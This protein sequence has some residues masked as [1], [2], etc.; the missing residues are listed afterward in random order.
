[1][2]VYY[3]IA[4]TAIKS[5]QTLLLLH[6][7][8]LL[9]ITALTSSH[10]LLLLPHIHCSY[11]TTFTTTLSSQAMLTLHH[12]HCYFT[13]FNAITFAC[14]VQPAGIELTITD[15]G[16][17]S[18]RKE[19]EKRRTTPRPTPP[20]SGTTYKHHHCC[21]GSGRHGSPNPTTRP[22]A[23]GDNTVP[24]RTS[25]EGRQSGSHDTRQHTRHQR[26]S[27]EDRLPPRCPFKGRQGQETPLPHRGTK[28]PAPRLRH[29]R[30]TTMTPP[31]SITSNTPHPLNCP[32]PLPH[33]PTTTPL[34]NI[35][36]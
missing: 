31:P 2:H 33:P 5:S 20:K 25:L 4:C 11:F 17:S 29:G 22:Y 36:Q 30:T 13:M 1:M 8:L 6:H 21:R 14:T 32:P 9:H 12:M 26:P 15:L 16:F 34:H 18:T 3:F 28:A 24:S 23:T 10:A 35:Y 7:I 19:K 27:H